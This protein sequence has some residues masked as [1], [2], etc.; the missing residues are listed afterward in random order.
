M[1]LGSLSVSLRL[2]AFKCVF[3]C[4]F[5]LNAKW[6]CSSRLNLSYVNVR[7]LS[8]A[9]AN[10]VLFS[11]QNEQHMVHGLAKSFN[12][13][14][15]T[16]ENRCFEKFSIRLESGGGGV[17]SMLRVRICAA[18]VSGFVGQNSQNKGPFSAD[19]SK[20]WVGYPEVGEK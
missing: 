5:N 6:D 15:T 20:L 8:S 9:H 12:H 17:H 13:I 11:F 19:F 1:K 4:G 14:S 2:S 16:A 7:N 18:H 10:S 3:A